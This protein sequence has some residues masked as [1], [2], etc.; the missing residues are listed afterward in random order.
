MTWPTAVFLIVLLAGA[1]FLL[2]RHGV[3]DWK[4]A[5]AGGGILAALAALWARFSGDRDSD[6]RQP[7]EPLPP[8]RE[9]DEII[10]EADRRS[11]EE[12]GDDVHDKLRDRIRRELD[13]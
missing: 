13:R 8:T 1:G 12:P 10:D 9:V 5:L 4:D 2:V 3:I 7:P 11:A 6:D